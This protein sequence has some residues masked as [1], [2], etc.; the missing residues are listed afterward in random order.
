M[1]SVGHASKAH[2]RQGGYRLGIG[3]ASI[4]EDPAEAERISACIAQFASEI[5]DYAARFIEI[6]QYDRID[7]LI[8]TGGG[9]NIPEVRDALRERLA[10]IGSFKHAYVPGLSDE[11]LDD[12]YSRLQPLLVRAGTAL[13]GSSVYFDFK[14]VGE[15]AV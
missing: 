10:H 5:A 13:G 1:T 14:P 4:G 11:A 7:D 12:H 3:R 6:E 8:L 9:M 2:G 15:A